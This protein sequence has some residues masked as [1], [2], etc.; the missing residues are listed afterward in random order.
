MRS[1]HPGLRTVSLFPGLK[2]ETWGA[3]FIFLIG[4]KRLDFWCGRR[5]LNPQALRR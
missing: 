4:D 3:R 5:D 1:S 2:I